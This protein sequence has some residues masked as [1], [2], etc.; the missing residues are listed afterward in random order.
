MTVTKFQ[1]SG[2][3][4]FSDFRTVAVG[5]NDSVSMSKILRRD[6]S[7]STSETSTQYYGTALPWNVWSGINTLPGWG[8]PG[9]TEN[10]GNIPETTSSDTTPQTSLSDFY[11][12]IPWF[13]N[14]TP[15]YFFFASGASTT[16]P[17]GEEV[18]TYYNRLY[19]DS[20]L[21][22]SSDTSPVFS[23]NDKTL[24]LGG[25]T[26]YTGTWSGTNKSVRWEGYP[27][28]I[29]GRVAA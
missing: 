21:I 11:G 26:Y 24:T 12:C 17:K 9:W 14:F 16:G 4:S 3:I 29:V 10:N 23:E 19:W 8:G 5:T 28:Y 13:W 15:N 18:T 1:T 7:N 25:Y 6:Q 20:V 27:T 22:Y 2:A